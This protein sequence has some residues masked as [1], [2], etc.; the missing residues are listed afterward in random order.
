MWPLI[1]DLW[2]GCSSLRELHSAPSR[3]VGLDKLGL[4]ITDKEEIKRLEKRLKNQGYCAL[5]EPCAPCPGL[6]VS[7]VLITEPL[8]T[9]AKSCSSLR[10]LR[11]GKIPA[12]KMQRHSPGPPALPVIPEHFQ[13][14][15]PSGLC[16]GG[17][18]AHLRV[19]ALLNCSVTQ[20]GVLC[21][22]CKWN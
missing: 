7:C 2:N 3:G 6:A 12:E 21:S 16:Q 22:L 14:L 1:Q 15:L 9:M 18:C 11:G 4:Q 17:L 8:L 19:A 20:A 5:S 13:R 10:E